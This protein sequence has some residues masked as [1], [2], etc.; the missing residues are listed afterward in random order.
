MRVVT[1]FT[2]SARQVYIGKLTWER[3]PIEKHIALRVVWL[4][5]SRKLTKLTKNKD[6]DDG[7]GGGTKYAMLRNGCHRVYSVIWM[8]LNMAELRLM[9]E[10]EWQ[11]NTTEARSRNHCCCGKAVS[12]T[13]TVCMCVCRL[14][15][16]ACKAHGPYYIVICGTLIHTAWFSEEKL[17]EY[18]MRVLILSKTFSWN[19]S[20]FKK[21]SARSYHKYKH[22]FT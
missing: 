21:N 12:V 18:K 14:S 11:C 13:C 9:F 7:G 17:I 5:S 4:D 3:G 20:H 15:Y 1:E 10:K 16:P 2:S 22:V 6:D 8:D 19:I